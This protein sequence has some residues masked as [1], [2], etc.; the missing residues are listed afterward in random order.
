ML[1]RLEAN[2]VPFT[3][4]SRHLGSSVAREIADPGSSARTLSPTLAAAE[5][6][7]RYEVIELLGR[8]GMGVVYKVRQPELNRFVALKVLA[9]G[10]AANS[11][12]LDRF[13]AEAELLAQ[14]EHP[15]LVRVLEAGEFDGQPYLTLEYL[16]GGS[17]DKSVR[18]QPMPARAAAELVELLAN[19]VEVAHRAGVTHRDIKPAN[20]LHC[21]RPAEAHRLWFGQVVRPRGDSRSASRPAH[22]AMA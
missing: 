16:P 18:G 3:N 5:R 1:D 15:N 20:V 8:G 2:D 13:R 19:A 10:T 7:G 4:P 11:D 17:L 6:F 21:G 9:A 12:E 14:L 22:P